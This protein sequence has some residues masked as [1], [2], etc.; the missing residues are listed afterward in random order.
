MR[1]TLNDLLAVS[2]EYVL[3]VNKSIS[4]KANAFDTLVLKY[5][6]KAALDK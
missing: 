2:Y 4:V 1:Q 6:G 3:H 5:R